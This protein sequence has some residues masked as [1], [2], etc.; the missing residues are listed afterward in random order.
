MRE[1]RTRSKSR[2]KYRKLRR[3]D[4]TEVKGKERK[5]TEKVR[6]EIEI[7]VLTDVHEDTPLD[8]VKDV[9]D[10]L[11]TPAFL[12]RQTNFIKQVASQGLPVNIKKGHSLI[13]SHDQKLTRV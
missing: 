2:S 9:V 8:E 13:L 7:P 12:C 5:G 6:T 4:R 11:Q 1:G 3:H 10:I